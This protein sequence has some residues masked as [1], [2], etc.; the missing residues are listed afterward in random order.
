LK[1]K[2]PSSLKENDILILDLEME[3]SFDLYA[4]VVWVKNEYCGTQFIITNNAVLRTIRGLGPSKAE[5]PD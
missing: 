2:T 4:R 1:L 5:E 3:K